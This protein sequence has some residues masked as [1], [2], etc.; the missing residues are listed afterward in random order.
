M[1]KSF[2][3]TLENEGLRLDKVLALLLIDKSRTYIASLI[4]EGNVL[5]NGKKE[6]PSYKVKA[7]DELNVDS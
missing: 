7:N 2:V 3:I 6:K 5:V 4:D 1:N